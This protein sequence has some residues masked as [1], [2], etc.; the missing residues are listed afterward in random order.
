M[1]VA[2]HDVSGLTLIKGTMLPQKEVALGKGGGTINRLREM[3]V[4]RGISAAELGRQAKVDPSIVRHIE[5]GRMYAYPKF[6]RRVAR[7]LRVSQ[8][9][10][11]SVR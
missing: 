3:R 8:K 10:L 1:W 4:A 2:I 11:F 6:R 7:V 5:A 9:K